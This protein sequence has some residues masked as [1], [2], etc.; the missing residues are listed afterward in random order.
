MGEYAGVW[1]L[2]VTASNPQPLQNA[3]A[4]APADRAA[5]C[6]W[7]VTNPPPARAAYDSQEMWDAER[8]PWFAAFMGEVLPPY[9]ENGDNVARTDAWTRAL[10]RHSYAV[11]AHKHSLARAEREAEAKRQA[12]ERERSSA[13]LQAKVAARRP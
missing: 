1:V 6:V 10:S 11:S 7:A 12:A 4:A 13:H 3:V 5:C 9:P 8:E 2:D